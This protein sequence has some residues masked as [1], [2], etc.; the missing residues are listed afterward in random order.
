MCTILAT[1]PHAHQ[2]WEEAAGID[3]E[4]RS[5]DAAGF[6]ALDAVTGGAEFGIEGAPWR[7][8]ARVARPGLTHPHEINHGD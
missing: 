7:C 3:A 5:Q 2:T 6:A 4:A 1:L 8:N